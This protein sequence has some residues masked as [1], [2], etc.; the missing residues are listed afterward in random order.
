MEPR[1]LRRC[2]KVREV[3][4][5]GQ[6]GFVEFDRRDDAV[7]VRRRPVAA[8]PAS[9][10]CAEPAYGGALRLHLAPVTPLPVTAAQEYA[11]RKMDGVN[12]EGS[13]I[14]VDFAKD[15]G[16]GARG[17]SGGYRLVVVGLSGRTSWQDLKV[18]VSAGPHMSAAVAA[19][20]AHS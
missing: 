1:A 6:F 16:G 15:K 18:P 5:K 11:V 2:G 10:P 4:I 13:R 7:S 17:G 20:T 14:L 19:S 12:V 3:T 8:S 9:A